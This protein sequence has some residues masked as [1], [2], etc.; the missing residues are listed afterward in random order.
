MIVLF[1]QVGYVIFLEGTYQMMQ[2]FLNLQ[3]SPKQKCWVARPNCATDI[4]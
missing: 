2:D 1:P 3:M 4:T